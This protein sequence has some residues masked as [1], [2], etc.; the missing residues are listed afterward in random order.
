MRNIVHDAHREVV[1]GRPGAKVVENGLGHG[2]GEVLAAQTVSPAHDHRGLVPLLKDRAHVLVQRFSQ[3]PRRL[4]S[5]QHRDASGRGR[6]RPQEMLG[7]KR[8]IEP[9]LHQAHALAQPVQ[10]PDRFIDHVATG[11]HGDNHPIRL[12]IAHVIKEIVGPPYHFSH[13]FHLLLHNVGDAGVV[14]IGALP[15]LKKD[16]RVLGRPPHLRILGVHAPGL[17]FLDGIPVHQGGHVFVIDHFDLLD[18]IGGPEP[19]EKMDKREAGPNTGQVGHQGQVHDLLGGGRSQ[20]RK[21]GLANGVDVRVVPE[22]GEGV[23][24]HRA[25]GD[26]EHAGHDLAGDLVHIGNHQQE[27]LRGRKRS[28]QGPRGQGPVHRTRGPRLRL[29]LH[30][31]QRLIEDIFSPLCRPLVGVFPHAA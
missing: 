29:Q 20:K 7:R 17:E 6:Q 15:V 8:K 24:R 9:H 28:G 14:R 22:D 23:A 26:M 2:G 18:F 3:G 27:P 11:C 12:R 13:P 16:I 4:G 19:V 30:D 31:F 10:I 25:G 1:L 5:V 21:P